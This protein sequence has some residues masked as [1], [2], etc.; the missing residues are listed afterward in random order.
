MNGSFLDHFIAGFPGVLISRAGLFL[1][2]VEDDPAWCGGQKIPQAGKGEAVLMDQFLDAKDLLYI[3]FGISSVVGPRFTFR[4]DQATL[5]V[6]PN[7]LL[8]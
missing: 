4:P 6:F 5:F 1:R 2:A 3:R 8:G 7:P